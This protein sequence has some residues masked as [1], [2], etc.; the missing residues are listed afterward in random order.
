MEQIKGKIRWLCAQSSLKV[1]RDVLSAVVFLGHDEVS[2]NDTQVHMS[3]S[4]SPIA[5]DACTPHGR[6]VC[7]SKQVECVM[8]HLIPRPGWWY[9]G[10]LKKDLKSRDCKSGRVWVSNRPDEMGDKE[11]RR[12]YWACLL[13]KSKLAITSSPA[14]SS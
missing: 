8:P 1:E 5:K 4:P 3:P 6:V 2:R 9:L 13:Q 11:R 12:Y 10:K 14:S 7:S